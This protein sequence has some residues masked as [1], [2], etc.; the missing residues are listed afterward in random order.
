MKFR[1]VSALGL[2]GALALA[3]CGPDP[4]A[5]LQR[6]K[7]AYAAHDFKAAQLDL[8]GVLATRPADPVVLELHARTALALGDGEMAAASL[9]KIPSGRRPADHALLSGEAA[10]LRGR[11]DEARMAVGRLD[12]AEAY[13]IRA[14]AALAR[15]DQATAR[16][17]FAAGEAAA[18]PPARLFAD[19][20]RFRLHREDLAGAQELAAR[21]LKAD[22]A[23]LDA[24]L[25]AAQI[26][27]A[28]GDL[29]GAVRQYEVVARRWPGNLAA[30][31]G[32]A[33][34]LGDLGR[35]D[36][37]E[38][39]LALAVRSGASEAQLAWLQA[40]AAAARKDWAKAREI[41]QANEAGLSGRSDAQLLHAQALVQ[42]GQPE[43]AR[44]RLQPM[45]TR[46]PG[47][48]AVRRA[49]AQAALA[50]KD[51]AAAVA[52]LRPLAANPLA[53]AADLR[54]L[55][56]AARQANVPDAEGLARRARY[57][58]PQELARALGDADTA[59]KARN[60]GNAITV[61]ERI[62]AVTDGRSALVL[63]NL[64]YAHGQVGNKDRA[65]D[66]ALR[67][68]KEAPGNPSVMD[69]AGW[70]LFQTGRDRSRALI[71]L[72]E[73]SAKAPD[74]STIAA[75]LRAAGGK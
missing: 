47:N 3:A 11:P 67:A 44:A 60:W 20:A 46:Q 43:Q 38:A 1:S 72:Q 64:A 39:V 26:A 59:M 14:L 22:P 62:M 49:L 35:L 75:H 25:V 12:V 42:L 6:A 61:Y 10:L 9:G 52:A 48:L 55:A 63:N 7:S 27:V 37:M 29:G 31:T 16:R 30:L 15:N 18:G 41:L 33:G 21:A 54:L 36:E 34:V 56:D 65:L 58:A 2:A 66:Y 19:H 70:L 5:L 74:N 73:A 57:P 53:A 13:R 32:K 4:D 51:P 45:L 69:T 40:R 71:L 28:K 8:A 17:E 50:G 23:S 68:L 24:M